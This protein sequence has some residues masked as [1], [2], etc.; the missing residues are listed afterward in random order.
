[1]KGGDV[2]RDISRDASEKICNVADL[3]LRIIKPGDEKCNNLNPKFHL[4]QSWYRVEDIP[5]H[6]AEFTV[7]SVV[8]SFQIHLVQINP[9]ADILENF[10]GTVSV[11][12]V[13]GHKSGSP[14][15]FKNFYPPFAGNQGFI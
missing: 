13:R 2:P 7:V 4:M 6:A 3:S 8:E 14:G 1:M 9:R 5:E 11:R 12:Y 15:N 10:G